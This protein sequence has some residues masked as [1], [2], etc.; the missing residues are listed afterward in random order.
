[1]LVRVVD[2]APAYYVAPE[3]LPIGEKAVAALALLALSCLR[4]LFA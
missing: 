3:K 4:S 2:T 1:M